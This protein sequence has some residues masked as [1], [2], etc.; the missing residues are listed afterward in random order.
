M[1]RLN[2]SGSLDSTFGTG[3]KVLDTRIS[4]RYNQGLAMALQSNGQIL[5][6]GIDSSFDQ[7]YTLSR[8]NSNGQPDV[9]FNGTGYVQ[10]LCGTDTKYAAGVTVATNGN[11]YLAGSCGAYDGDD[12]ALL[13][14]EG[15]GDLDNDGLSDV[16]ETNTGTYVSPSNTGTDPENPDC[17][18]D[19][20]WDG[21]ELAY[22][23]N[24]LIK[25]TDGDGFDDGYEVASGFNPAASDSKPGALARIYPAVEFEFNAAT[26]STYRIEASTD[27]ENWSPIETGVPGN[28]SLINRFYPTRGNS[29]RYFRVAAE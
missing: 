7:L 16:V 3:G 25:D 4:Y 9:G 18:N 20:L 28:G 8:Y 29:N 14:Y 10:T 22:G 13:R 26:G 1:V 6:C 27:L 23:S 5:T 17:D 11:I 15:G 19:G 24:P 21:D 2:P 12:F